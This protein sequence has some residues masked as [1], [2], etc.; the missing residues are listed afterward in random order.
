[1]RIQKYRKILEE[2]Q[3]SLK[4]ANS[5]AVHGGLLAYREMLVH[6]GNVSIPVVLRHVF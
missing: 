4:M 1:M 6:T 3:K 5:D 2:A